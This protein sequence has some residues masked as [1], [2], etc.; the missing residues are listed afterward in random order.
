[1]IRLVPLLL[2][3][4]A[5][6]SVLGRRST[7]A[8]SL[9]PGFVAG[10]D[11][12]EQVREEHTGDGVRLVFN[13]PGA[14]DP[15]LPSRVLFYA[16]PNGNTIEQTL[17]RKAGPGIDWHYDIQHVAA[18]VRRLRAL[19][20]RENWLLICVQPDGKSWPTW[21]Q[22][23]SD[24][25]ARIRQIVE[26]A[27]ARIPGASRQI[28]LA[29]HS[30]GGSF[31]FGYIN[32]VDAIPASVQRIAF[33][34]ANYAYSDLDH[35]GEKLLAWLRG[36]PNR[37]LSVI[38][39][40]DRNIMLD[41]KLVVGPEGGTYRA[42]HRM[43]SRF[44]MTETVE[45]SQTASMESFLAR[46][47]QVEIHIALN[48]ANRILHTAL[49]GEW[50]G[51]LQALTEGTTFQLGWGRF[52]G[53][54][55]YTEWISTHDPAVPKAAPTGAVLPDRPRDARGGAAVM[56]E[57]APLP[58]TEREARLLAE[59]SAGNFPEFLR[60][61]REI[62]VTQ[63]D[64]AGVQHTAVYQ[65]MPDYLGVGSDAEFVRTPMTP[66]TAQALA[67]RWDCSLP[68]RRM[69][70][71]IYAQS[72]LQLEPQPLTEERESVATFVKQNGLIEA[73]RGSKPRGALIAG[74]KKDVVITNRL[75][76]K[77]NRVAIYGW[78]RPGGSPIQPLTIVHRDSY[79][80]YSHGIRLVRQQVTVDGKPMRLEEL[81]RDPVLSVLVSDEGPLSVT[82]YPAA[83][84][85]QK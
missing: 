37:H 8:A 45:E 61:F 25:G 78:H 46:R 75:S 10:T 57:L 68:T 9:I 48:P 6:V 66:M 12:G 64:A 7:E 56:Q 20:P 60:R 31:L 69:V 4:P 27:A 58:P 67:D 71:A 84:G 17:G 29:G 14:F 54:R 15:T 52:G 77:P 2:L 34:D 83:P 16:T 51:L 82:R 76:E 28:V 73:Q 81:L 36:G 5:L 35:H 49:V 72:H 63:P 30:G 33:L 74:I 21:R 11:F 22:Q 47:G 3:L 24:G 53:P 79:V 38:A 59:L 43:L 1:M 39:Y 18:Q 23:H 80:D 62:H 50:N 40:D 26:E 42:S 85:A 70:D 55:A 32:A 13:A 65:V 41:G 19:D 44:R